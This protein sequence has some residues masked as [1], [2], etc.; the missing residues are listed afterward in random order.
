MVQT[1]YDRFLELTVAQKDAL[2]L[3]GI[4]HTPFYLDTSEGYLVSHRELKKIMELLNITE[5]TEQPTPYDGV[6]H[7]LPVKFG[8]SAHSLEPQ[9]ADNACLIKEWDGRRR[10]TASKNFKDLVVQIL[11]P[12]IEIPV[13]ISVPHGRRMPSQDNQNV[14]RIFC[15]SAPGEHRTQDLRDILCPATLLG[16]NV[17]C[18]D[19]GFLFSNTGTPIL[20][21]NSDW[22]IGELVNNDLYIYHDITDYGT[23]SEAR[24]FGKILEKTVQIILE[25]QGPNS[26]TDRQ[27]ELDKKMLTGHRT[28]LLD[29]LTK[30]AR[31]H[32]KEF[33]ECCKKCES[34]ELKI[35]EVKRQ[36]DILRATIDDKTEF[37]LKQYNNISE[38]PQVKRKQ[39][40]VNGF[41]IHTNPIYATHC[42]TKK[43]YSL[44]VY[45]I[46]V[47]LS[48][49]L[50]TC[51]NRSRKVSNR[52]GPSMNGPSIDSQGFLLNKELPLITDLIIAGEFVPAISMIFQ[53]LENPD[54]VYSM[55]L[56]EW[57]LK[58]N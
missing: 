47:D 55:F 30:S 36:I 26:F 21:D 4:E 49:G 35:I 44:G 13:I 42:E 34:L 19:S 27:L 37:L 32:V 6:F 50:F 23:A 12:V 24:L 39:R 53:I 43:V 22:V 18:R 58:E 33:K 5:V 29:S 52:L 41:Q 1:I 54:N 46:T 7:I 45:I 2:T 17:D 10:E 8:T 51:I 9:Y 16:E 14:F 3:A 28:V 38:I 20:D 40:Q 48:T 11:S 15:W 56:K 57:P 25:Q 31:A